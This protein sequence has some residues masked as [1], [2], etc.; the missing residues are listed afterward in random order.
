[1]PDVATNGGS[2]LAVDR[3]SLGVLPLSSDAS[4]DARYFSD[5]VTEDIATELSRFRELAVVR[6]GELSSNDPA[7]VA[8]LLDVRYVL[9]GSIRHAHNRVRI[10]IQLLDP[11]AGIQIWADRFDGLIENLLDLQAE[12][13]SRV[14]ASITSEIE[15]SEVREAHRHDATNATAYDL[16]LRA[17]AKL[18]DGAAATDAVLLSDAIAL[19]QQATT[20]DPRCRRALSVLAMAHCRRGV[21]QGIGPEGVSDLNAADA[22]ARRL[23]ELDPSDHAAY[24]IIGHVAMRRLR[25]DEAI[26][27]L[28]RAHEL[29]PNEIVTLRWLSWEESNLGLPEHARAHAQLALRLGPRDRSIDL[30]HWALALAEYVAGDNTQCL[31]HAR[32][33]I[34]LNPQFVGHRILL[35]ACLAETGA[36]AEASA[37]IAEIKRFAPGLFESRLNGRTYFAEAAM[38]ERYRKALRLAASAVLPTIN[39][40][41]ARECEVLRLVATGLSNS[42]IADQLALSEHTVK[43]HVANILAKLDLPTR[44]AAVAEAARLGML[45]PG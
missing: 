35:A 18:L 38:T 23:R 9:R 27:N 19:A 32:Q 10:S 16:A 24:A 39:V 26:S 30:T 4:A 2:M 17:G 3:P 21:L 44:A 45:G 37:Q 20:V 29:N 42:R 33:A 41:T 5:G 7:Q 6:V 28:R 22:A 11:A 40:L 25:H 12:I 14:A 36:V 15:W 8:R 13:A 31:L 1:M 34:G 43:R